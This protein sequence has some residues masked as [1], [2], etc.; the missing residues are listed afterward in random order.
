[1]LE[2]GNDAKKSMNTIATAPIR[3]FDGKTALELVEAGRTDDVVYY[4]Q[5]FSVGWVG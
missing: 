3:C 5:S 4:L 2:L 1:M